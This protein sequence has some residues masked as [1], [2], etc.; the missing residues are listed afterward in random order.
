MSRVGLIDDALD[1]IGR[2]FRGHPDFV[3]P[4]PGRV[5]PRVDPTPP[6]QPRQ[7]PPRVP[8]RL[9]PQREQE[10]E[11]APDTK[12]EPQT[13]KETSTTTEEMQDCETCPNCEPRKQ[14]HAFFRTLTGTEASKLSG[15][16]YSELGDPM[17]SM[18]RKRD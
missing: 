16:Q 5:V 7:P 13:E 1:A 12:P 6:Q 10:T 3:I 15:A 4:K 14:G 8:P 18:D 11:T 2:L 9:P 17:V